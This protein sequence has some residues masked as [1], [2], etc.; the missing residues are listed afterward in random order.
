MKVFTTPPDFELA[1]LQGHPIR[2]SSFKGSKNVVLIFLRSFLCPFC[3]AQL[4]RFRQD[5]AE[6]TVRQ[7]EILALGPDSQE[8]F[9]R[10]WEKE[11]LPFPGLP[12]PQHSVAD[13]YG[14]EVNLLKLGRMPAMMLVDKNGQVRYQHYG[15]SMADVADS[16]LILNMLDKINSE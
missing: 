2:L 10:Y 8:A 7:A 13:L 1:D 5:Y 6:F 15:T 14:Q 11:A 3:R 16:N 12:D 4:A 9:R